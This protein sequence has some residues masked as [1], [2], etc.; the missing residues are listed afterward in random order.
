MELFEESLHLKFV[1]I[2]LFL[3]Q[4]YFWDII[5]YPYSYYSDWMVR[6]SAV[7]KLSRTYQKFAFVQRDGAASW[8]LM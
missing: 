3:K 5:F 1:F 7:Q 2:H 4:M 8:L 6:L